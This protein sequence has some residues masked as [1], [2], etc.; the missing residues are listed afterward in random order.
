MMGRVRVSE[1]VTS[2]GPGE[3]PL[4]GA[5]GL[6][7]GRR[8]V[9]RDRWAPACVIGAAEGVRSRVPGSGDPGAMRSLRAQLEALGRG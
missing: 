1:Q 7:T 9:V 5:E 3:G 2:L 6:V 4:F 8:L